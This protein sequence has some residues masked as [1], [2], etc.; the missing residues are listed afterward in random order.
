MVGVSVVDVV[1]RALNL[2]VFD[3]II[4]QDSAL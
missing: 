3:E 1:R 2:A 4:A